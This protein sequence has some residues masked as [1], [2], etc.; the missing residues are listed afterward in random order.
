MGQFAAMEGAPSPAHLE[1]SDEG[2]AG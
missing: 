1:V 2:W